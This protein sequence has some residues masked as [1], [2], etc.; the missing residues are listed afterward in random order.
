[1]NL[2]LNQIK[3]TSVK[4]GF[5]RIKIILDFDSIFI[6]FHFNAQFQ[7]ND[8]DYATLVTKEGDRQTFKT[9]DSAYK[10]IDSLLKPK[11][12]LFVDVVI[13]DNTKY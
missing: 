10:L 12:D 4:Q 6:V 8:I 9:I 1:M 3:K 2:Q 11:K 5:S 13:S 7:S